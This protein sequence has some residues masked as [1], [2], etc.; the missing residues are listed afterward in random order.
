MAKKRK[1]Q[2]DIPRLL[3]A[4]QAAGQQMEPYRKTRRETIAK[5]AG[6]HWSTETA[7]ANRPINFLSLYMQIVSRNLVS[8][9]PRA[10]MTT[11]EREHRRVASGLQDW[12]NDEMARMGLGNKLH[13]LVMDGLLSLGIMK[14]GLTDPVM[15][16][17]SGWGEKYGQPYARP[18]SLDDFRFDPHA[19][20]IEEA[21]W[22]ACRYRVSLDA[23]KASKMYGPAKDLVGQRD[24]QHNEAGDEKANMLGRQYI[25]D[26]LIEAYEHVELWEYYLPRERMI[27]TF[28][29]DDTGAPSVSEFLDNKMPYFEADYV[30]PSCGPYHFLGYIPVPDNPMPK[31]PILDALDMDKHLNNVFWKCIRQAARAKVNLLYGAGAEADVKKVQD[32]GDGEAIRVDN[33]EMTKSVEWGGAS[34]GNLLFVEVLWQYLNKI[35]GNI[36]VMGGLGAQADTATQEKLLNANTSRS[37]QDMQR[38]TVSCT[39]KIVESLAW[40]WH[41]HPQKE[42]ESFRQYQGVAP[43][44]RVIRPAERRMV[45]FERLKIQVDPYSLNHQS[46]AERLAFVNRAVVDIVMPLMPLMREQ[47][48][49]LDL[50]KLLELNAKY[51]NSPDLQEVIRYADPPAQAMEG[52][53]RN[54]EPAMPTS[55]SRTYERVSKSSATEPGQSRAVQQALAGKNPG[56]SRQTAGLQLGA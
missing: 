22:Y 30:G 36:E 15:A 40:Y 38:T 51:G 23:L 50:N 24:R 45:P 54:E 25:S 5:Y 16:E 4:T 53:G 34:Q 48:I 26:D 12:G 21:S 44:R 55:T 33:P 17:T 31:G 32:A 47:G 28:L 39:A 46:P 52:D 19:R 18:V 29:T 11:F 2:V 37:V 9:D 1:S 35:S 13:R 49:Y 6:P 8:H 43:I 10:T 56:G 20:A 14:V 42:M 3:L 27:L 41:H 7:H